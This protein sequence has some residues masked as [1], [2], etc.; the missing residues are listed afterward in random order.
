MRC[1]SVGAVQ[2]PLP[3]TSL[4]GDADA[5]P[6]CLPPPGGSGLGRG[7][8]SA[9]A[10]LREART[11]HLCWGGLSPPP[12]RGC[13]RCEAVVGAGPPDLPR[14]LSGLA[15]RP[16]PSHPGWHRNRKESTKLNRRSPLSAAWSL[17]TR[18]E[19][20]TSLMGGERLDPK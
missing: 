12:M 4:A 2:Q 9:R 20:G 7:K 6:L 19:G 17:P 11:S 13:P 14:C 5:V 3:S 15:D 18:S 16:F 1:V 10:L 8:A